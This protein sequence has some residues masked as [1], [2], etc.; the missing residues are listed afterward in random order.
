MWLRVRETYQASVEII[1]LWNLK[2]STLVEVQSI[3]GGGIYAGPGEV[4]PFFDL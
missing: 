2:C 1:K 3:S 4:E